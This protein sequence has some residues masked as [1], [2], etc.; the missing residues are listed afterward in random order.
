MTNLIKAFNFEGK[1]V[2]DSR[3]VAEMIGKQHA[4]LMRDIKRYI[5][6]LSTNPNLD[7][8]NFF[9][10]SSYKDSKGEERPCYLLT[11]QGCEM[12]ANKLTGDKGILFTAQY[13]SLFN[14]YEQ[15][16][17]KLAQPQFEIPQTLGEALQLAA[18][19]Q[20]LIEKNQPKVDYYDEQ[21]RNPGLMTMTEIA[22]DFGMSAVTLNKILAEKK[23]QF[24]QG[25]HWVI[26][27]KYA[28]KG[29][30]AYEPYAYKKQT[31]KGMEKG[32]HNNLKWTQKGRKFI[33]D[34]LAEDDIHPIIENMS[35]LEAGR[36][37]R[38]PR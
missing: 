34:L 2:I 14:K 20:K 28:G 5:N 31:A 27:Q 16:H 10:E 29:Y 17:Q 6:V 3:D 38:Q 13:V 11:K 19:Q 33:Y 18:D 1:Q 25:K 32:V 30:A 22:K 4:H 26:A 36:L 9:V 35:L 7:S 12:V 37:R 24:R 21:M 23:V 8:L 15:E